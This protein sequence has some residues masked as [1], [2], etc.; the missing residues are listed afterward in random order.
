MIKSS[1]SVTKRLNLHPCWLTYWPQ[2]GDPIKSA[3]WSGAE[4]GADLQDT[5]PQV[6]V[7]SQTLTGGWLT[8]HRCDI[9][10]RLYWPLICGRETVWRDCCLTKK[11]M[12]PAA[13]SSSIIFFSAS[14]L[15]ASFLSV[16][17]FFIATPPIRAARSTEEWDCKTNSKNTRLQWFLNIYH[18]EKKWCTKSSSFL[19]GYN[20]LLSWQRSSHASDTIGRS[21]ERCKGLCGPQA[22][23]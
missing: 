11:G 4:G 5:S 21:C 17:T 12:S 2:L 1:H 16:G 23:P 3:W 13:L 6:S 9:I 18:K 15:T 22:H 20:L 8:A 19:I 7:A 10:H 14:P